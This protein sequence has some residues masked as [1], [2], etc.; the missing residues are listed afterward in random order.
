MTIYTAGVVALVGLLVYVLAEGKASEAG[1]IAYFA[2]LL[3]TLLQ[4]APRVLT[5]GH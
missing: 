3:V 2:G 5:L 1:R 4:V